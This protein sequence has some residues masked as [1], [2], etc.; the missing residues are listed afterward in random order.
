[1]N[2]REF[3]KYAASVAAALGVAPVA[4]VLPAVRGEFFLTFFAQCVN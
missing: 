1:M 3:L 2:R 4:R